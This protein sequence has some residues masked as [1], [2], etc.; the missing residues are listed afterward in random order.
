MRMFMVPITISA[1]R[2][3]VTIAFS[4]DAPRLA[5][6]F[7]MFSVAEEFV[8]R[9]IISILSLSR[10]LSLEIMAL[11]ILP[12]LTVYDTYSHW[13][14]P[15]ICQLI[16]DEPPDRLRFVC[17]EEKSAVV[18]PR[19]EQVLPIAATAALPPVAAQEVRHCPGNIERT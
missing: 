15:E 4:P 8:P 16:E 9:A 5:R 19:D 12:A 14:E 2:T 6:A 17:L 18:V 7:I 11:P 13:F 3:V 10:S 1:F